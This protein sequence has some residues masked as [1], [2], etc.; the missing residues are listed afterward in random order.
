[1]NE[2]YEKIGKAI[3]DKNEE[4]ALALIRKG[5]N[6][7]LGESLLID[8]T[9]RNLKKVVLVL[10]NQGISVES[11]TMTNETPLMIAAEKGYGELVTLF[12]ER[13]ADVH[14]KDIRSKETP[15]MKAIENKHTEIGIMLL[16]NGASPNDKDKD[17]VPLFLKAIT[18]RDKALIQKFLEKGVNVNVRDNS[19]NTALRILSDHLF[20]WNL[21]EI[22]AIA[23]LLLSYGAEVNAQNNDGTT[24]LMEASFW[25]EEK[26]VQILLSHGADPFMRDTVGN[27]ALHEATQSGNLD[28]FELLWSKGFDVDDHNNNDETLLM[29]AVRGESPEIMNF[30]L[31]QGANVDCQNKKGQTP[32]MIA[33]ESIYW[34]PASYCLVTSLLLDEAPD[35]QVKD[36]QGKVFADYVQD[37]MKKKRKNILDNIFYK[38]VTR[39]KVSIQKFLEKGTL[40][41]SVLDRILDLMNEEQKRQDKWNNLKFSYKEITD[42]KTSKLIFK[43]LL[44]SGQIS[45]I[46]EADCITNYEKLKTLY[47]Q[48]KLNIK[49]GK[50]LAKIQKGFISKRQSLENFPNSSLETMTKKIT[51]SPLFQICNR[52]FERRKE[53]ER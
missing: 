12:L 22:P 34:K 23:E 28:L 26:M 44:R 50:I 31:N 40:S 10:L 16:E 36:H 33:M 9:F 25:G 48:A 6:P 3:Y 39:S 47:F 19:G 41:M 37:L 8:A 5:V 13:G 11:N 35:L 49:D 32:L 27:T 24:P 17:G 52:L 20:V 15:L 43:T 51:S 14:V 53:K 21:E 29:R 1:M 30:L 18:T 42:P 7:D 46:C 4:E 2:H 38:G 45:H